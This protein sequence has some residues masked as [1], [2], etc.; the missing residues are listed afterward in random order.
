MKAL[1]FSLNDLSEHFSPEEREK[2][3]ALLEHVKSNDT[4]GRSL[5]LDD[6]VTF[7]EIAALKQRML[8]SS[9]SLVEFS[10]QD[11]ARVLRSG[12]VSLEILHKALDELAVR[13]RMRLKQ[14]KLLPGLNSST[15]SRL[16]NGHVPLTSTFG[17][18][19]VEAIAYHFAR[20]PEE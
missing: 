2:I 12:Q 14:A 19:Y 13:K 10:N 20:L 7:V 11:I 16:L 6:S 17:Q 4:K 5:L 8:G 15:V 18:N 1:K 3:A 9:E